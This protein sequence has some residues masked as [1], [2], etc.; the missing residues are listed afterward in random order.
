M[1][2]LALGS[3]TGGSVRQPAA[4]CGVSGFKP[5]YGRISRH[6]LVAFGSSLDQ[7]A[8]LARSVRD[9]A[10]LTRA[11]AG[12][13]GRDA[14]ALDTTL[15]R[16][17]DG[18]ALDGLR[19]GVPREFFPDALDADV[20]AVVEHALDDLRARGAQLVDVTLPLVPAALS[21]YYVLAASEA[22]S[23]LARFDGVRYGVRVAGD[24]S[25]ASMMA[26]TRTHGFGAEVKRRILLGTYALSSGYHDA[27]YGRAQA[28]R[29]ALTANFARLFADTVDVLAGP[30]SPTPAFPLGER[31]DPV[32]MYASDV[33]TVPASLAQ[34]PAL[35]VPCGF[36]ERDAR[37]LP[38]GMQ[39]IGAHGADAL[40]LDAGAAFQG[41]TTHHRDAPCTKESAR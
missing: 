21:T 30:T 4:L 16:T 32:A 5:T 9:L 11:L 7:V 40:V 23:N 31:A 14:T 41:A 33:L 37:R 10:T 24:G 12:P 3:D 15:G 20:R 18:D 34:L 38:V 28:V 2:P 8:P 29:A 35:S 6:G 13:D 26:R 17:G 39:L 19:V 22:S 1:V 27:W 25:L 36:V